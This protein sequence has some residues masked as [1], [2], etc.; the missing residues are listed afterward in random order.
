MGKTL[1]LHFLK[2]VISGLTIWS[3]KKRFLDPF[4]KDSTAEVEIQEVEIYSYVAP[5]PG[6]GHS[7]LT[8]VVNELNKL[9]THH[10]HQWMLMV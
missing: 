4:L 2:K 10:H 9:D 8:E 1:S 5:N 7:I 6:R 3:Y